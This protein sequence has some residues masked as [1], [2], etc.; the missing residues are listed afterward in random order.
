LVSGILKNQAS[1]ARIL[2]IK[3]HASL[4]LLEALSKKVIKGR[5]GRP[6]EGGGYISMEKKMTRYST[7]LAIVLVSFISGIAHALPSQPPLTNAPLNTKQGVKEATATTGTYSA[8]RH[9]RYVDR[10]LVCVPGQSVDDVAAETLL[11]TRLSE[12]WSQGAEAWTLKKGVRVDGS[13]MSPEDG[14]APRLVSEDF[15]HW[16]TH[17]ET[18]NYVESPYAYEDQ[19]FDATTGQVCVRLAHVEHQKDKYSFTERLYHTFIIGSATSVVN[20]VI[21]LLWASAY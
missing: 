18:C 19:F 7:C 14:R 13:T 4:K 11:S 1:T 20:T 16:A 21:P 6:S 3:Q 2:K 10:G 9:A 12:T 5:S 17:F 8:C 15:A